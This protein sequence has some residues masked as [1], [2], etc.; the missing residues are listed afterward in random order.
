MLKELLPLRD[1]A[2]GD[3][4][5]ALMPTLPRESVIGVR[6]PALKALAK[7]LRAGSKAEE[8]LLSL[9]HRY[10]EENQLHAFLLSEE[11]DFDTLLPRLLAFLPYVDNWATCDQL[12]PKVIAKNP[13][14]ALPYVKKWLL[15]QE[16]YTVRFAI[17]VLLRYFLDARFSPAYLSLVAS[18]KSEAY[19]V[20]MMQA[21]YFA[22]ACA[23]QY[24]DTLPYFTEGRLDIWVHNKAIQK[25]RESYRVSDAHKASLRELLIRKKQTDGERV[26]TK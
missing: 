22:T 12:I 9:P 26:R 21:W 2:Y 1:E 25:A 19:Y 6:T 4:I 8:F 3:F 5:S 18:V 14:K 20:K 24:A 10:F 13:E 11:H 16:P 7:S 23:K 15:S 17:G